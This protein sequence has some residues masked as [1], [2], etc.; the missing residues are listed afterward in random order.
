[1]TTAAGHAATLKLVD[2]T[3]RQ[4]EKLAADVG[5]SLVN[6]FDRNSFLWT[7]SGGHRT[8]TLSNRFP[9]CSVS[10]SGR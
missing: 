1:M 6:V 5:K 7:A 3:L 9:V 2:R 8:Q 10:A 4:Q